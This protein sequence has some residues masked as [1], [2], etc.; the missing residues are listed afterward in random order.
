MLTNYLK[1]ALRSIRRQK[2]Y[3]AINIL[4]LAIGLAI[5]LLI[6]L[7]VKD[8]LSYDQHHTKADR[9]HRAVIVW[10]KNRDKPSKNLIGPYRLKPALATDFPAIEQVVRVD[11]VANVLITY[12]DQAFQEDRMFI[13]DP[14]IFEVFDYEFLQGDP[15]TALTE[16]FTL[17]LSETLAKK[18][19]KNENPLD[20][21]L[22]VFGEME[23]KVT[24][25]YKDSPSTTHLT[26]D[27][28]VSMGTGESFYNKLVLNNWSEGI[29]YNYLL[30]PESMLS[31]I[32]I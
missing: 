6:L 13:T 16:P 12:K 10:G 9:I 11:P 23:V 31:L 24:G 4:G 3:A 18:Y 2:F 30:L 27:G 5:S 32:H 29:C 8:E 26:A 15:K 21:T 19:F 7:F 20:K 14:E 17:V 25:V 1:I 28:L 22:T